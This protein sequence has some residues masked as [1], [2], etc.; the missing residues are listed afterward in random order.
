MK[1]NVIT[2]L[3]RSGSTLFCNILNQNPRFF[4]SS[5]SNVVYMVNSII[6]SWSGCIE[7]KN[8]L[9][10]EK[11]KTE[12]RMWNSLRQFIEGWY[13]VEGKD[14]IFDK[15]R[16]WGLNH[17]ALQNLFPNSKLIVMVRDIRNI[18][19]SIEKQYIKNPLFDESSVPGGKTI[20]HRADH[21]FGPEGIVG[22]CIVGV[23]DM[24]RRMKKHNIL[25]VIYEE[26]SA[27]PEK[28]MKKVYDFL[29]EE[30]FHHDFNNVKKTAVDPDS[31]YLNK[32]P[33]EGKGKVVPTNSE[34]WKG[35]FTEELANT[36]MGRF[37]LYN[38]FLGYK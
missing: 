26:L 7:V 34:E 31:F 15:S 19:S 8:L 30:Q 23:E 18:F 12:Q 16:G 14:I 24:I 13:E 17:L 33:H 25:F 32:Y 20:Y 4:A 38:S 2:G 9:G 27:N 11:E 1:F 3:P 28:C 5:T 36:I 37:P 21:M 35:Y 29:E 6:S 10:L 22:T